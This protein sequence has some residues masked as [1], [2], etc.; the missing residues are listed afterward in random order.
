SEPAADVTI[1]GAGMAG[2][3]AALRLLEAGFSVTVLEASSGVGGQFGARHAKR[4]FHDFAWHIFA[5]WCLNFW[6]VAET[7]G[8]DREEV[9]VSRPTLT[10]LRP[11][12]SRSRWPRVASVS[13]VGSPEAFW[14]DA[15]S[16]VAHWS[17]V[18]LY[19]YSLYALLCDQELEREEFLNRVEVN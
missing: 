16:G 7:I 6:R 1:V 14:R 10:L 18:M 17:D 3:T 11:R 15:T 9:F 2:M 5:D 8:I 13:S 19:S 12:S 4:G